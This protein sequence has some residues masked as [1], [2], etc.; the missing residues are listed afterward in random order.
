[1]FSLTSSVETLTG[2]AGDDS[3]TASAVS[4]SGAAVTTVQSGD[5]IVGGD[6]N[7]TLTITATA[8][9]NNSLSGLS[10]A[11]VEKVVITGSDYIASS[12]GA[13]AVQTGLAEVDTWTF[14][15][16]T[17]ASAGAYTVT[18]NGV[19]YSATAATG[20]AADGTGAVHDAIAAALGNSATVSSISSGA[21]TVTSNVAGVG[22]PSYTVT[23]PTGGLSLTGLKADTTNNRLATGAVA[24][25]EV[26]TFTPGVASGTA[27]FATTDTYKV[28]IN[29]VAYTTGTPAA[30][31][32]SAAATVVAATLNSVL[33]A[34]TAVA[35]SNVV[36][37]GP[38]DGSALPAISIV[39]N[40]STAVGVLAVTSAPQAIGA[41]TGASGAIT[42]SQFV[43]ATEIGIDGAAT[44]V[45]ALT[46]QTVNASGHASSNAVTLKY[47]STATTANVKLTAANGT[48][49]LADSSTTSGNTTK[50]ILTANVTGSVYRLAAATA[51]KN[52]TAGSITIDETLDNTSDTITTLNLGLTSKASVTLSGLSKVKT[53]DA[54]TSTGNLT[55]T[56]SSANSA[57]LDTV[58]G[59]SGNDAITFKF[60]TDI[61]GVNAKASASVD[62]GAGNDVLTTSSSG[63]GSGTVAILGGTGNDTIDMRAGGLSASVTVDGGADTDTVRIT[64]GVAASTTNASTYS[65]AT[66]YQTFTT[67]DFV[68]LASQVSNVETLRVTPGSSGDA[69]FL[70]ASKVSQFTG[71]RFD[72]VA[73]VYK[74]A[75]SQTITA[76][77]TANVFANGYIGVSSTAAGLAGL[78]ATQY[79]GAL[80]INASGGT[81]SNAT[82][83]IA[84]YGDSV[85]LGVSQVATAQDDG[86]TTTGAASYITLAGDVKT[87]TVNLTAG[88]DYSKGGTTDV[89]STVYLSP[90]STTSNGLTATTIAS[91]SSLT[92]LGNLTSITLSGNGLAVIDNTGT[93]KLATINASALGGVKA[94]GANAGDAT[95]GLTITTGSGIAETVTLGS[96]LDN[97]KIGASGNIG[98]YYDKM[99]TITGLNLVANSDGTLNTSKSDDI[100]VYGKTTS[101]SAPF[102]KATVGTIT[103]T[104]LPA[105]L[106]QAAAASGD[107][108]VFQFGGDT[109]IFADNTTAG[110]LD[111]GDVVVKITGLVDLDLLVLALNS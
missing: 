31:S 68:L 71:L 109:Y 44:V 11:G 78:T 74:V 46:T 84:A 58:K 104:T 76:A 17:A 56:A 41:T 80:K 40:S 67:G 57:K 30:A 53:V 65:G 110:V 18:V 62:G 96:G 87:A 90:T 21:F 19:T 85:T 28:I 99:D 1:V 88:A 106:T 4:S 93:S 9:N 36:I 5:S 59:G 83:T 101:G 86:D 52:A 70:D 32:A 75:D 82:K 107:Q 20:S 29:G 97:V 16:A 55:F 111:S 2:G 35:G 12:G 60:A 66:N 23:A 25:R 37:S 42:A 50:G 8:A 77:T 47:S 91:S 63:Y 98:S 69:V 79:Q 102:A 33:G 13:A 108:L 38:A 51:T 105:A 92:A 3:F 22:L 61:N 26:L 100:I 49:T 95:G 43:G 73:T 103:A 72:D 89:I 94:L 48:V 15:T 27:T 7:D 39:G 45:D 64:P 6:G 10:V 14:T 81:A 34:N 24:I 54:S